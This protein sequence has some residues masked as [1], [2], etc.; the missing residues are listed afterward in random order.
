MAD[1]ESLKIKRYNPEVD[2]KP[3]WETYVVDDGADRQ[4]P[5]RH[6]RG[7]VPP[8][9]DP[10]AASLVRP[11][12]LRLRRH[13][14]QRRQ[15]PGV[16]APHPGGGRQD[17]RRAHPRPAGHQGPGRRH[18]AVLRP[19]PL[20]APLPGRPP[21]SPATGSG[22][23]RPRSGSASTTRPSA[24]SAPPARRR[25]RSSGATPAT[26][27]RPPSSTPTASSSTAG[28]RRAAERLDILNERSGVWR[29]R[30]AFNCTDACPRDIKVTAGHRRG[31][32]GDPLLPRL[33][34]SRTGRTESVRQVLGVGGV[35]SS[36]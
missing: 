22:T 18:G 34:R 16:H 24:S 19:V 33:T 15:P 20:G 13:G 27:A 7:Q 3:H 26:W 23:R 30:T 12:G 28:T 31:E 14:H 8:R 6:P 21:T 10:R 2:T 9:R 29:C 35:R 32:A 17:H 5:R 11:R 4:G 36:H 1:V 25:A